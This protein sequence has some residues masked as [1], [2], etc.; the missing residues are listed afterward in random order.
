MI[1]TMSVVANPGT[2]SPVSAEIWY[3]LN[4]ASSSVSDFKYIIDVNSVNFVTGASTKLGSFKVP[5]R[6]VNGNG[7][8]TSHKLLRSQVYYNLNPFI[9][10]PTVATNS[11]TK[12]NFHY[13]F[14]YNPN[15][16]YT[17]ATASGGNMTLVYATDPGLNT[18]DII[19]I[20]K[21][22][23]QSNPQYDGTCSVTFAQFVTPYYYTITDKIYATPS[24]GINDGGGLINNIIRMTGTSSNYYAYNGTRQ[25]NE[26]NTNFSNTRVSYSDTNPILP[27]TNYKVGFDNFGTILDA[28]AKSI[29]SSQYETISTIVDISANLILLY[30]SY[31]S[32]KIYNGGTYSF[33]TPQNYK[34]IDIPSG[35]QNIKDIGLSMSN[36]SYYTVSVVDLSSNIKF[37]QLYKIVDNCSPYQTSPITVAG[38]TPKNG[39]FRIAF[40]NRH[41]GFDYWN[42]NYKAT[43]TLNVT[44]NEFRKVLDYNYNVGDRQDTVLSQKA[45]ET[46]LI[47][48]DWITQYDSEFLKELISSPE[49]YLVD[50]TNQYNLPIIVT[51]SSYT[52]KTS[53][54]NKLFCVTL[55]F[56][57]AFDINLQQS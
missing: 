34:R 24:V 32:N 23:K 28:N 54:D 2:Y 47:S 51:D 35:T 12:Y 18:N 3:G 42:F 44:K 17:Q 39:V 37:S 31:D 29:Y 14:Q 36:T 5:P 55:S 11:I 57:M 38:H 10:T 46:Y 27:L 26:I 20:S 21:N 9:V 22:N 41:G 52:S 43:N 56:K 19:T 25:Y 8:F 13:G 16:T 33:I 7:L 48:S 15:I 1:A 49:V 30:L 50:E 40:L 53:I 4:S 45:N 6:P